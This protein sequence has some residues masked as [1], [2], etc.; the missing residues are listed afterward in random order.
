M[1][2]EYEDL[3]FLR[4]LGALSTTLGTVFEGQMG[5]ENIVKPSTVPATPHSC[6][7]S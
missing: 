5:K 6:Q 4:V 1:T 2:D 3:A 7:E